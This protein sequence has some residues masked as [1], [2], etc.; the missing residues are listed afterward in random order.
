MKRMVAGDREPLVGRAKTF[1]NRLTFGPPTSPYV[2]GIEYLALFN[3]RQKRVSYPEALT[4]EVRRVD[5]ACL[6]V[7]ALSYRVQRR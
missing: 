4:F 2:C 6:E 1:S 7:G 5:R 3:L